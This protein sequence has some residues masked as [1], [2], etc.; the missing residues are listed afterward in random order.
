MWMT[1]SWL[2]FPKRSQL[3]CCTSC[4]TFSSLSAPFS[5]L[6]LLN[7]MLHCSSLRTQLG[8]I[9]MLKHFWNLKIEFW[10]NMD[11]L[12]YVYA[13]AVSILNKSELKWQM[14]KLKSLPG[15]LTVK[16]W[17]SLFIKLYKL[18]LKETGYKKQKFYC[19]CM[20]PISGSLCQFYYS[21]F[22]LSCKY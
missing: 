7:L 22:I 21:P 15:Q 2:T 8:F 5:C 20:K 1:S 10:I 14:W 18:H 3:D 12:P 13:R 4:F 9:P 11:C 6:T 16:L 17:P 19:W